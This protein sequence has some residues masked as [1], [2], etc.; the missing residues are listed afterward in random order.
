LSD[1]RL[2]V[3]IPT[4]NFGRFIGETIDSI[5]RQATEEVEIVV[6]DGGRNVLAANDAFLNRAG[7]SR[8][9]RSRP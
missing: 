3:C 7:R 5:V 8:P 4:Y 1:I 6:L 9:W 2:S